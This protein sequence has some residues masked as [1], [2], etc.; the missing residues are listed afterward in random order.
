MNHFDFIIQYKKGSKMPADFLSRNV[1]EE[2]DLF[3]QDLP[4]L[5]ATDEFAN[6]IIEFLKAQQTSGQQKEGSIHCQRSKTMLLGGWHL[7]A[8]PSQARHANQGSF[9]ARVFCT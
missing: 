2:I 4:L 9:F 6:A 3:S 1:L 8:P 7:V 5:Q